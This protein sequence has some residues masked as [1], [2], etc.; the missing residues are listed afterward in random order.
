MSKACGEKKE[1]KEE[2]RRGGKSKNDEVVVVT[3]PRHMHVPSSTDQKL[4]ASGAAA[5]GCEVA[6]CVRSSH[7]AMR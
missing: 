3:S 5:R 6:V 7:I 2:K 4:A 1:K